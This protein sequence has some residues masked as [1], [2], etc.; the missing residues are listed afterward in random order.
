MKK[1]KF[2]K[3]NFMFFL[4]SISLKKKNVILFYFSVIFGFF[5]NKKY[6]INF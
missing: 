1:K 5:N 2:I 3:P 6:L 4:K